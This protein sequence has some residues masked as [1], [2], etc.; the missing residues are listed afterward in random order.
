[1]NLAPAG[2]NV[3]KHAQSNVLFDT[4]P[5]ADLDFDGDLR[6]KGGIGAYSLDKVKPRWGPVLE[7][8]PVPLTR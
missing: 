1:M 3:R 5:N 6:D 8:K 2:G 4:Y 7:I